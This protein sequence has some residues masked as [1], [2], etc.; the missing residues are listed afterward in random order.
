MAWTDALTGW[1]GGLQ[2]T[3]KW[4]LYLLPVILIIVWIGGVIR[5][6]MIYKFKVRV[7]RERENG[8]VL[9]SN[10]K[11]GYIGRKNLSPFFRVK[12][13]KWWWQYVDFIETPKIQ[14]MDED[15]R[16]YYKQID[17]NT[18]V[19]MKRIIEGDRIKFTPVE[20][21]VKYGA[22]LSVQKI[23]QALELEPTWKKLLPYIGLTLMAIIFIVSYALL[24]NSCKGGA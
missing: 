2:N 17:V 11:G 18:F 23:R 12:R 5:N 20:S 15:D 10:Y 9:E 19:Q 14:Y 1:A 16:L 4:I 13:G 7:F 6:R 22:V 8:K 21:D 3:L 24:M